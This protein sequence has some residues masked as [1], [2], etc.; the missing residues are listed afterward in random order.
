MKEL[1]RTI[2]QARRR[3]WLGR[4]LS[5]LGWSATG[6]AILF[7]LTVVVQRSFVLTGQPEMLLTIAAAVLAAGAILAACLWTWL[8]RD[9][10]VAAA[11]RLDEAA[12]LKERISSSLYCASQIAAGRQ[13]PFAQAVIIDARQAGQNVSPKQHLPIKP[14]QSA[15]YAGAGVFLALLVLWLFPVLDLTG[16][17]QQQQQQRQR[18]ELVKRSEA[19][20]RPVLEKTLEKVQ[21]KAPSLKDELAALEPLADAK[22]DTPLDVQRSAMKKVEQLADQLNNRRE[23]SELQSVGEFKKMMRRLAGQSAQKSAVGQLTQALAKGDF[24]NARAAIAAIQKQ[25][26]KTPTTPQEKAQAEQLKAQLKQ[27]SNKLGELAQNDR[28][29]ADKLKAAGLSDQDLKKAL[30]NLKKGD[31]NA[32]AK[33]LAAKGLSQEQINKTMKQ[34]QSRCKA[35]SAASKLAANLGAAGSQGSGTQGQ[36]ASGA[37]QAAGLSAASQQLSQMEALQQEL[38][39]LD[40]AMADLNAA[41]DQ[42]GNNCSACNGTGMINGQPCGACM[43]S[44]RG[45]GPKP[46]QGRGGVAPEQQT[47]IRRVKKRT[48]VKTRQGSI[49]SQR[50]ID[51]EQYK[52]EVSQAFVETAISAQRDAA[53]AIARE[54]IPRQYHKPLKEYFTRAGRSLPADQ[55]QQ[56]EAPK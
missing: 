38:A 17:A 4:W 10:L 45:M 16:A 44:G 7:I 13:D 6:A 24:E 14:P 3:L 15:G 56:Q 52:G 33:Q 12:G 43:G 35:C 47:A 53:D 19:R 21:Q 9:T 34:V 50:F 48:D 37:S 2:R 30:E 32:I 1:Q 5:S 26:A 40:S 23:N 22:L 29:I 51:G 54:R 11:A 55:S 20:M 49:I 42:L 18:E 8:T 39:Q 27:L 28:K 46:G 31:M 36:A 25:L 41:Q